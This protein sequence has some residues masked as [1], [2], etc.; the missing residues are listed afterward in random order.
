[1]SDT[2]RTKLR[3]AIK[4]NLQ[5]IATSG[6]YR[7]TIYKVYDPPRAISALG[8]FPSANVSWGRE[9]RTNEHINGNNELLDIRFE[10]QVDVFISESDDPALAQDK[11]IADIQQRFGQNWYIQG[12]DGERTAFNCLF[13]ASEPFGIEGQKPNCG[14]SV[15]IEVWY[16]IKLT[17]P[18]SM[19]N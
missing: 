16:R 5:Q 19:T 15:M 11:M 10:V 18:E 1:M 14:V 8:E 2:V 9:E 12:S 3:E 13:A 4:W 6:G 17:N 7:S